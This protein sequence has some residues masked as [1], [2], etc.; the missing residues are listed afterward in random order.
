MNKKLDDSPKSDR[1]NETRALLERISRVYASEEW[2]EGVNPAQRAALAYL[3]RANRFS[4][5]PSHVAEYLSTTR[6]TASQTLKALARKG[7]I[8]EQRSTTDKRSI[9]YDV[10]RTGKKVLDSQSLSDMALDGFS[11]SE[12]EQL[13]NLLSALARN[14][15]RAQG[16][17]SFGVCRTCKFHRVQKSKPYCSLLDEILLPAETD[18]ICHEH[19]EAA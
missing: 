18:E 2:D 9:S 17:K 16:G 5:S 15:L 3:A 11:Q 8:A 4:R 14:A 13:I 12:L 10:S 19:V 7:L 6:G 1:H